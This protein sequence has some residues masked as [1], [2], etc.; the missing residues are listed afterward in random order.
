MLCAVRA[1]P[2]GVRTVNRIVEEI[3]AQRGVKTIAPALR[4]DRKLDPSGS[5]YDHRLILITVNDYSLDLYNG[6]VG[7]VLAEAP[8]KKSFYAWFSG[9]AAGGG[10]AYRKIA[11]NM[12]PAHE[13]AFAM[14]VHKAHG[15][16]FKRVLLVLTPEVQSPVLTR[17]L[18][19][20]GLTR[21]QEKID[22][23][24][25]EATF[26]AAVTRRT[27]RVSRLRT[28]LEEVVGSGGAT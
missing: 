19:Y 18:L 21:T 27:R 9:Q 3:L 25:T 22:L 13:T 26:K 14:T 12:L 2:F 20:T 4:P 6:D 17:K 8:G 24:C 10:D 15:S 28:R 11:V 5:F 16:E 23:W 7:V 1:G